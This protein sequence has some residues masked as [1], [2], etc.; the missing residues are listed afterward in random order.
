[1][2][3]QMPQTESAEYDDKYKWK[4][5][6][7][8]AMGSLMSTMDFSIINIAFPTLTKTFNTSLPTVMWTTLAYIL[9]STSSMMVLGKIS[10]LLGRKK[11]YASGTL[12]LC[13]GLAS[14]S[15]AQTIGQLIF[16]RIIQALGAAMSLS[17]GTAIVVEAFPANERGKGLGLLS[18]FVSIGFIIGPVLGGVLLGWMNW[19]SIFFM[20]VPIGV[21]IFIMAVTLLKEQIKVTGPVSLDLWG[22]FISSLMIFCMVFGLSRVNEFG[23][24]SPLVMALIG[25]GFIFFIIFVLVEHRVKDPIVDLKLFKNAVFSGAS[26]CLFLYFVSQPPFFLILPFYLIQGIGMPPSHVGLMLAVPAV[27]SM[28]S[29]P[30]S[31]RL[32]DRVGSPYLTTLGALMVTITFVLFFL[33]DLN[34]SLITIIL[35]LVFEGIALGI[36]GPPNNSIIMGNVPKNRL[37]TASALIATLRQVGISVGMALTGTLYAVRG[38]VYQQDLIL[39]GLA[40]ADAERA[41]IPPAFHDVL[42]I[43]IILGITVTIFCIYNWRRT[44]TD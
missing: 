30:I 43:S 27:F 28:I 33:F 22:A 19:Q 13:M 14:C 41:A 42:I 17:A 16:F 15:L 31:G 32:S 1:M 5:L 24:K 21:I 36:F 2:N 11:M 39:K 37:G 18:V 40:P 12:I 7:T 25:L 35:I 10:D 44:G 6:I 29:G 34:T 38:E 20:R 9:M 26:W 23:F 8:V 3:N 4:A